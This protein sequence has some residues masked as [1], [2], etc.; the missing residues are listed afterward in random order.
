MRQRLF[1]AG[2]FDGNNGHPDLSAELARRTG[3]HAGYTQHLAGIARFRNRPEIGLVN[4]R[5]PGK[6]SGKP[7]VSIVDVER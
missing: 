5:Q 1:C 3:Q 7:A 4:N 2:S 6:A